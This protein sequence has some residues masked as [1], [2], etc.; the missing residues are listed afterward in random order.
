MKHTVVATVIATVFATAA[1]AGPPVL[2]LASP[3]PSSVKPGL[4]V[5]YAYPIDVKTLKDARTALE[6]KGAPGKPLNGLDYAEARGGQKALSSD[7]ATV[8]AARIGGYMKFTAAGVYDIEVFSNDG[9]QMTL[10]GQEIVHYDE[11]EACSSAGRTEVEVPSPGWYA[12]S[13]VYFQRMGGSCL[14]IEVGKDGA[15]RK[16]VPNSAFG[17]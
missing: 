13:A 5:D 16:Q 8:V 4:R 17:Y 7:K 9:V 10:G 11:R 6:R 2:K 14:Q 15:K 12:I 1:F 3:Q